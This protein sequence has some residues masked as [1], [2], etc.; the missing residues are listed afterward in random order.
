MANLFD[1]PGMA[2]GYATSR[3]PVHRQILER[4]NRFVP[5]PCRRA[6]DVGC[7]AGLSTSALHGF[8]DHIVGLEPAESMVQWTPNVAPSAAF[9][10]GVAEALPFKDGCTD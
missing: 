8:A 5:A 7:G 9:L 10:V 2:A 1:A 4:V 3:P 6:I